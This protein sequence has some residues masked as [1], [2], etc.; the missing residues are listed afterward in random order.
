MV[1]KV[2]GVGE[3]EI[4]YEY[5]LPKGY[6]IKFGV[7]YRPLGSHRVSADAM[8]PLT[9]TGMSPTTTCRCWARP[10]CESPTDPMREF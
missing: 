7:F 5:Q 9:E 8:V 4:H 3:H 6:T 10:R 2:T 1:T